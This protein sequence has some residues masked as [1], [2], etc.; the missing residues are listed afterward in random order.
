LLLQSHADEIHLLPALPSSW[1]NGKVAGLRARGGYEVDILWNE[2]KLISATIVAKRNGS[3]TVR[4]QTPIAVSE[5]HSPVTF[6][7]LEPIKVRFRVQAG[8]KYQIEPR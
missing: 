1:P 8:K 4:T 2:G 5:G 7:S 3:C 6:E